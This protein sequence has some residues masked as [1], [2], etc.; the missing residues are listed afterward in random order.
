MTK[1]SFLKN[2]L[3]TFIFLISA[4]VS[5]A[6][7]T[8]LY[9]VPSGTFLEDVVYAD[10]NTVMV[11]G[12]SLYRTSIDGGRN[13]IG[14]SSGGMSVKAA[15][16][17]SK[18]IGI[19]VGNQ[20]LYRIN[21]ECGYFW[22]WGN[23]KF[24][25]VN[26][27]LL[28]VYFTD[29]QHG[30][31]CGN[32][33]TLRYTANQGTNWTAIVTGTTNHIKGVWSTN[34][35][36]SY[37]CANGGI[38]L[39]I[40]NQIVVSS[41]VLNASI[42]LNKIAFTDQQTG[43]IVG[44]LGTVYKTTDAGTTWN[45]LS[46]PTTENLLSLAFTST[47]HGVITGTNGKRFVTNDGGQT[48]TQGI[49]VQTGEIRSAAFKN[50]LEGYCVGS[51]FV[52]YTKDGG[53]SWMRVDGTMQSVHFPTPDRGYA[54]GYYGVAY[55]TEDGGNNWKPMNLNTPQYLND[56]YFINRD[57]GYAVGGSKVFRTLDGGETWSSVTNP[58]TSSLYSVHFTDYNHGVAAGYRQTIMY[59]ANAG[60]TWT[61]SQN[62]NSTV[63]YLD[64][65]FPSS[66]IGFMCSSSGAVLKSVNGGATWTNSPGG[67]AQF[68]NI[69]FTD[70]QTGWAVGSG[71]LIIH[72][73]DGGATWQAQT[74]GVTTY[75][76]GVHFLDENRGIVV[77]N[78]GTYLI[79]TDGGAT[80][81]NRTNGSTNNDY[82]DVFFT[83]DLHGYAVSGISISGIGAFSNFNPTVPYCPG[84]AIGFNSFDPY[85][86]P[87]ISSQVVLEMTGINDDFS[88]ASIIG[89]GIVDSVGLITANIPITTTEGIYKTRLRDVNDASK[90]SFEKF[91]TVS[92]APSVSVSIQGNNLVASSNQSVT[93][94]WYVSTSG[95]FMYYASGDSVA[96]SAAGQYYVVAISGCCTTYSETYS[97]SLCN[98]QATFSNVSQNVSICSG[99]Q[100]LVGNSI[101]TDAGS[102]TDTLS[103]VAGC[104][105]VV[106]TQLTVL[107]RPTVNLGNDTLVCDGLSVILDAGL[108]LTDYF[109]LW[110]SGQNTQSIVVNSDGLYSVI[111]S[112]LSGCSASD[113]VNVAFD[114]C[115]SA[116]ELAQENLSIYPNPTEG[117]FTI[118][119]N[120]DNARCRIFSLLGT[121][122]FD[123]ILASGKQEIALQS[124]GI[125]LVQIDHDG[126]ST[127]RKIIVNANNV[128]H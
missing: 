54:C 80:W 94:Q 63:Y 60:Q 65:K 124:S 106:L 38:V 64:I 99:D 82:T 44:S 83:N 1:Q 108:G 93:F 73:I 30:I 110:N 69:Y 14:L 25:G 59:T 5:Q 39:K 127:S 88:S 26:K 24:I 33:G 116:E 72:T 67:T 56:I 74:S 2:L 6:Q 37:A 111:V 76:N 53:Y 98:G 41:T 66:Q 114:F 102:Y 8:S 50:N 109:Y 107:D 55:K 52:E 29:N 128:I 4:S 18:Q 15:H 40:I 112:S 68:A 32:D 121:C 43:F 75:L 28:D 96:I 9:S 22:G 61:I 113:S 81:L 27:D 31:V 89:T 118:E 115:L 122:V 57:T 95:I 62:S 91:I 70:V 49:T 86:M 78:A 103:N 47:N 42:D 11:T 84:D 126:T 35:S 123:A 97:I 101:Y 34:D 20:G 10:S 87:N 77:G 21:D 13:W 12:S 45:L 120:W 7:F 46:V 17:P 90:T 58:A 104:D 19:V 117:K 85:Y 71:G 36:V 51:N 100:V 23:N 48:W 92:S 16:F 3:C 79:T 125:Y 105:S 119:S